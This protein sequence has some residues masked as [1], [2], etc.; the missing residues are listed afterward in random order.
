VRTVETLYTVLLVT[1][2]I[3]N[4]VALT[5][6]T[7]LHEFFAPLRERR[8][9]AST[10]GLD[11]LVVP[12][13]VIGAAFLLRLDD[14]ALAGLVIVA[15][16]SAGPIG[17][18]L[19]RVARGDIPLSVTLVTGIGLLNLIT[20]PIISTLLLP[21]SV[22]FPVTPVISSLVG[23][24][25]VPLLLGR[26]FSTMADGRS[27]SSERRSR[28]LENAGRVATTSLAGAVTVALFL[29]PE[30]AR[31][32]L[33][34]PVTIIAIVTMIVVTLISRVIS[35]DP[36]RRRTIA[37]V[38]NARAVGLALTLTALH[39][40]DVPGLRAV[41]LAYGGLTQLVPILVVVGARQLERVRNR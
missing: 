30:L 7:P 12:T 9:I 21:Q 40:G 5:G 3:L 18:A 35:E 8:L 33:A 11:T 1:A 22:P 41:V 23:L 37:V 39:F 24:L 2:L 28:I 15:A 27:M 19:S 38:I 14:V 10:V 26:L 4:G 31:E 34:G 16:S 29:E 17:V 36:A 13:I 20:V 32:V 25:I 6:A